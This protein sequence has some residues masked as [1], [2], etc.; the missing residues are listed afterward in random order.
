M[1]E[2]PHMSRQYHIQGTPTV[3]GNPWED[4]PGE[5]RISYQDRPYE[6]PSNLIRFRQGQKPLEEPF[7]GNYLQRPSDLVYSDPWGLRVAPGKINEPEIMKRVPKYNMS[8]YT[9]PLTGSDWAAARHFEDMAIFP[10]RNAALDTQL[11]LAEHDRSI[12]CTLVERFCSTWDCLDGVV[13]PRI[14][15]RTPDPLQLSRATGNK[16]V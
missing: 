13:R 6:D 14:P 9:A 2:D 12:H 11:A 10:D 5:N 4:V 8:A 15:R 3:Y 16:D 1:Q 7:R